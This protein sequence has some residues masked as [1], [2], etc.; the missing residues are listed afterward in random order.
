VV[1]L[2][3]RFLD[4]VI[5]VNRYPFPELERAALATRKVGLGVMG[6][7]ELLALLGIPY[8]GEDAL[9]LAETIAARIRE[10]ART[11]SAAL[12]AERGA[13]PRF[14][15]SVYAQN[16]MPPLRNA[17]L[18]S[19]APTGT[20]SVIAGT[21]AGIEPMFALAYIRNVLGTRLVELNPL[22]ERTARR[23][24]FWSD[25]LAATILERGTLRDVPGVPE[26]VRRAF[27]TALEIVPEAHVR[28]QAAFQRHT[29]AAVSKTVNLPEDASREAVRQIFLS[30]W[31]A[32]VKGITVYRYGSRPH[33]VLTVSTGG[34]RVTPAVADPAYAGGCASRICE[35]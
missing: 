3:V 9:A 12:A 17:Q 23:G 29:D 18:T 27:V 32:A 6:F 22:F 2:A 11:A 8:D 19:I 34:G 26:D 10:E 30:A 14:A 35:I 25:D 21:T 33:Q 28:I 1:R 7:A 24:G 16:G 31:H 4:D 13:F 15:D 20:I 5:E